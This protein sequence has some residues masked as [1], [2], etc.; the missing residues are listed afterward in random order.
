[1]DKPVDKSVDKLG[2]AVDNLGKIVDKSVDN[3]WRLWISLWI[4][5]RSDIAAN[6]CYNMTE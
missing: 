5:V 3:L 4:S 2:G 6:A 1:M